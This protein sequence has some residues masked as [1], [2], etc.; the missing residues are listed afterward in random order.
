MRNLLKYNFCTCLLLLAV[1]FCGSA[2]E[3]NAEAL[4]KQGNAAYAKNQFKEAAIAYQEVLDAGY[5]SAEVYFNLG[6]ANYKLSEISQAILNYEKA[7]K[8]SPGDADIQLNLQLANL[9]I[10]DRIE[11]VPEFFLTKWWKGFIYFFSLD[12]LSVLTALCFIT[13][14]IFLIAYLFLVASLP[15]KATFYIGVVTILLGIVFLIM[16]KVQFH[17][18]NDNKQGIVFAGSADVK[19][20]PDS[21][22]KTLFVIHDGTKVTIL[23]SDTD[24]IKVTLPNGNGGWIKHADVKEI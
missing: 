3:V 8:I 6:N 14:F 17:Y 20:G 2:K 1:S 10:T 21:K 12:T 15:K 19:S 22:Q 23:D 11:V 18:L 9:K 24:W 16:S 4:F 7:L 5:Q 13:G